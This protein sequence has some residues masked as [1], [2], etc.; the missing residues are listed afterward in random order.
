MILRPRNLR[1]SKLQE[2]DIFCAVR[3]AEL[4]IKGIYNTEIHESLV[5]Q[6]PLELLLT[7]RAAAGADCHRPQAA[8]QVGGADGC[9]RSASIEFRQTGADS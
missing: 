5:R 7:G 1:S 9:V 6:L 3:I 8:D 2:F 4:E